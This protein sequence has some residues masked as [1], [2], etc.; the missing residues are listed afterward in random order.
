MSDSLMRRNWLPRQQERAAHFQRRI[1]GEVHQLDIEV[2]PGV[3][4]GVAVQALGPALV[5]L[6]DVDG[7]VVE[8][9]IRTDQALD[10]ALDCRQVHQ[11]VQRRSGCIDLGQRQTRGRTRN[12]SGVEGVHDASVEVVGHQI[13]EAQEA[14]C[15]KRRHLVRGQQQ[16]G[17][18]GRAR[19]V[20]ISTIF[21][22]TYSNL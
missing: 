21:S 2:H 16:L 14:A 20:C 13:V 4:D 1:V 10:D 19:H 5:G 15:G 3:D 12:R 18:H 7:M 6:T 11:I 17:V 8:Q 22:K 9:R